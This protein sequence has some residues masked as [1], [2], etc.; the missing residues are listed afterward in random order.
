[1]YTPMSM[2]TRSG[3]VGGGRRRG[4]KRKDDERD[5][6]E[7]DDNNNNNND[8]NDIH[9]LETKLAVATPAMT[10]FGRLATAMATPLSTPTTL[11]GDTPLSSRLAA[12]AAAATGT[13]KASSTSSTSS[14]SVDV[15]SLRALVHD[16]LHKSMKPSGM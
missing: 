3:V 15:A 9:S 10:T 1:M 4:A 13:S 11:L 6:D 7:I 8:I 12:A 5:D 2:S 14:T 16:C